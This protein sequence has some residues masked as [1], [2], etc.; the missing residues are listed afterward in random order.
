MVAAGPCA[1]ASPATR[2][3]QSRGRRWEAIAEYW[4]CP[5]A[6]YLDR[7]H[8]SPP[9]ARGR[10][11][12]LWAKSRPDAYVPCMLHD[13]DSLLYCEA[14]SGFYGPAGTTA[15]RL[16]TPERLGALAALGFS[17]DGSK[18]NVF[19][20]RR[21]RGPD[22]GA[23]LMIETLVRGFGLDA[24]AELEYAAPLLS[25]QT[26]NPVEHGG[27][28]APTSALPPHGHRAREYASHR[29]M[30]ARAA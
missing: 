29:N 30:A 14:A 4:H 5:V 12:V 17:T 10:Y 23:T 9:E 21:Y 6:D 27:R 2:P 25:I 20:D 24:E 13:S 3:G 18:G 7:I 11:L 15:G 26:S 16:Q 22:D 8:A 1:S 19:Q 28:C